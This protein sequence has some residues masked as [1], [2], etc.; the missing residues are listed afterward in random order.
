MFFFSNLPSHSLLCYSHLLLRVEFVAGTVVNALAYKHAISAR[1]RS[2][3]A[4][5]F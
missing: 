3:D 2:S 4:D 1:G 5:I